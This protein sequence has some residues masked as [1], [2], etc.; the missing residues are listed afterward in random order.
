[1]G[2]A[3]S[4]QVAAMPSSRST[5]LPVGNSAPVLAPTGLSRNR[6][7]PGNTPLTPGIRVSLSSRPL[8]KPKRAYIV[9]WVLLL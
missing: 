3:T 8:A 5:R 4:M 6:S 9:V 1:M 7:T 2:T